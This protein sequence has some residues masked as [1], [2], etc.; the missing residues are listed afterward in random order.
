M[1]VLV[2]WLSLFHV[3][4]IPMDRLGLHRDTGITMYKTPRGYLLN[5]ATEGTA[6]LFSPSGRVVGRYDRQGS[7]PGE[8]HRQFVLAVDEVGIH[9]CSNGRFIVSFDHGLHLI[10]PSLP[11]LPPQSNLNAFLGLSGDGGS[12]LV[13]LAGREHLFAELQY[14][15]KQWVI[16]RRFLPTGTGNTLD[17]KHF[18]QTGKRALVHH[19]TV[20]SARMGIG[21][22]EDAYEIEVF[23]HFLGGVHSQ[24]ASLTLAAEVEGFPA[25]AGVK[26]LIY[27][28]V[29]TPSGYIVELF[30]HVRAGGLYHRWQDHFNGEGV[31]LKRVNMDGTRLLPVVNGPEVFVVQDTGESYGLKRL[32]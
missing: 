23:D 22:D 2:L 16:P 19:R 30:S 32:Y 13:S 28:A 25:T 12:I 4:H 15:G 11:P 17:N 7:G 18:L 27:G 8:F 9:F 29:R 26:A 24:E 10:P 6:V 14:T 21:R 1:F 31:F 20:F 3:T 5:S